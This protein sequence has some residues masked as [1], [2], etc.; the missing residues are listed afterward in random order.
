MCTVCETCLTLKDNTYVTT[1][2]LRKYHFQRNKIIRLKTYRV[3]I[4]KHNCSPK[5]QNSKSRKIGTKIF[6]VKR[7]LS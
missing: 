4:D 6:M 1:K 5:L 2:H 3:K 7:H